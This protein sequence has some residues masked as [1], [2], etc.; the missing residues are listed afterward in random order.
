MDF[1]SETGFEPFSVLPFQET[2]IYTMLYPVTHAEKIDHVLRVCRRA[3]GTSP[4]SQRLPFETPVSIDDSTQHEQDAVVSAKADGTRYY[5]CLTMYE[6]RALSCLVNRAQEVFSLQMRGPMGLFQNNSV[7]D[8]ELCRCVGTP[9]ERLF[10][11]FNALQ[12]AGAHM[13][14]LPYRS[15][16]AAVARTFSAT[17]LD[18]VS[19][20]RM[21]N[22]VTAVPD[23]LHVMA[24]PYEPASELRRVI[25]NESSSIFPTDGLIFTPLG[26]AMTCGRNPR[27]Q[28]FKP[29]HTVDLLLSF[30]PDA[31]LEAYDQGVA[32]SMESVLRHRMYPSDELDMVMR[33]FAAFHLR[34][35]MHVPPFSEVVELAVVPETDAVGLNYV[36]IRRDKKG[37]N[38]VVTVRRTVDS[39]LSTINR[40]TL[41]RMFENA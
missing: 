40:E 6:G 14:H 12:V 5:L 19:R 18:T 34:L 33:G 37:A 20:E 23:Q 35:G 39:A 24:K 29:V 21:R 22:V 8:G 4:T 10:L 2:F 25:L 13:F 27:I 16:L 32:V 15:R 31:R 38:D 3:A 1:V 28:K 30:L 9:A 7:F 11:V 36:K 17:M 41:V 26:D